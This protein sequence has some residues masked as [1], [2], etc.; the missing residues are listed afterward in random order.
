M[1]ELKETKIHDL[2]ILSPIDFDHDVTNHQ[3]LFCYGM[4]KD[5]NYLSPFVFI[6]QDDSFYGEDKRTFYRT[7]CDPFSG[8]RY[9]F[10]TIKSVDYTEEF[11]RFVSLYK[12]LMQPGKR[13][14]DTKAAVDIMGLVLKLVPEV[15]VFTGRDEM[16]GYRYSA[17]KMYWASDLVVKLFREK[18]GLEGVNEEDDA[19]EEEA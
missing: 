13:I 11:D 18:V 3:N 8:N 10:K 15:R 16:S 1:I 6:I 19:D 4:V 7:P 14:V 12:E 9:K 17:D 2:R 5:F